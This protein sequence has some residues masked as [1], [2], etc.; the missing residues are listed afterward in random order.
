MEL[1]TIIGLEIHAQLSTKSKLW[2]GCDNDAFGAEPNTRVCPVCMGFPGML[3]VL[4]KE[5]LDKAVRGAAALRCKIQKFS[6]FDRKNYFYPDLPNGFQISQYDQPISCK[7]KV[8][9]SVDG[10]RHTI[11][12][13]RVHLENDAGKLVHTPSGTLC[14]Y[15]RS[16]T[17]LVEIVTEPDLRSPEEAQILAKEI[18]KILRYVDASDAD[19][20]KGMMRFDASVSL[21]HKG[22]EKLNPRAEIKNLNSFVSLFKALTYEINRQKKLW[23]KGTPPD[24][25]TTVGW[26]DNEEKTVIMRDKES[27]NDYRYFPEPDLPPVTFTDEAIEDIEKAVAELPS[28]KFHRYRSD[29]DLGEPEALKLSEDKVLADFFEQVVDLSD[30]PKKSANFILSVILGNTSWKKSSIVPQQVADVI[31]LLE[32]GTISSTGAKE[33]LIEAMKESQKDKTAKE[34]MIDLDLEQVSSSNDLGK[35]VEEVIKTNPQ[36]VDDYKKGK[37]KALQFLMGQ[38]MQI[39]KGSANP[40]KVLEML[41]K[42]LS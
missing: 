33:I 24:K 1:E 18:Q 42:R 29:F 16:G 31:N 15:N 8:E 39:S 2:C 37:E 35:W 6:K 13:T 41:K 25:E 7:G 30:N 3:P 11:G 22:T 20:E 19:M 10:K 23:E 40:P 4:N 12:I 17:P 36:S 26:L 32:E 34:L 38:V 28:E 27:A 5:G 9:I 14:D 21:R